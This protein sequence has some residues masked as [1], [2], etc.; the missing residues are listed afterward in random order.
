MT[1]YIGF[2]KAMALGGVVM[3]KRVNYRGDSS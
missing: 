2:T 3:S 1:K